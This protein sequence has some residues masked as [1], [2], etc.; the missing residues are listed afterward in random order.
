MEVNSL[1]ELLSRLKLEK[2]IE[3]F[4]TENIDLNLFLELN[5]ADLMEIGIKVCLYP[6]FIIINKTIKQLKILQISFVFFL[7]DFNL[8]LVC[9]SVSLII[10]KINNEILGIRPTQENAEC[11]TAISD[12]WDA[13]SLYK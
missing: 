10:S 2:Y 6:Y 9:A 11:N 4:E 13:Y 12:R 5:D 1:A 7:H 3:I 8:Y